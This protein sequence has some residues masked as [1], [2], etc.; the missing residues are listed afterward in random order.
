MIRIKIAEPNGCYVTAL[1]A[2]KDW[3]SNLGLKHIPGGSERSSLNP[4]EWMVQSYRRK[5][6]GLDRLYGG[7]DI[8]FHDDDK[9]YA[10]MFKLAWV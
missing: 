10:M 3:C 1:G 4:G 9:I 6:P 2:W 7:R 8:C 5:G